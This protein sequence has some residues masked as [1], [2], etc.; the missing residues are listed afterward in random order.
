[1]KSRLIILIIIL[2]AVVILWVTSAFWIPAVVSFLP[3]ITD[4][5]ESINII[6]NLVQIFAPILSIF[7]SILIWFFRKEPIPEKPTPLQ[8]ATSAELLDQY[9]PSGGKINW[10]ERSAVELSD[11]SRYRK[12][13]I[14]GS[15]MI[16]KTRQAI[17]FIHQA[18]GRLVSSHRIYQLNS[19]DFSKYSASEILAVYRRGLNPQ[20]PLLIFID[21]LQY[22]YRGEAIRRLGEV[23]Q[24]LNQECHELYVL[25]TARTESL[26]DEH[27]Q[28]LENQVNLRVPLSTLDD[29]LMENLIFA[30]AGYHQIT[31]D[32]PL[33]RL[34]IERSRGVPQTVVFTL[35]RLADQRIFT[36]TLEQL[37]GNIILSLS[38]Q[39][40]PNLYRDIARAHP[41][42]EPLLESLATF[43]AVR[44]TP[45]TFLVYAYAVELWLRK[46]RWHFPGLQNL[47]LRRAL[48]HLVRYEFS[49]A[50]PKIN[51]NDNLVEGFFSSEIASQNLG[52]FLARYRYLFHNTFF[53]HLYPGA[54][55]HSDAL[56][57]LALDSYQR[58]DFQ[59]A[60]HLYSLAIEVHPHP[61]YYHNRGLSYA[62]LGKREEAIADYT[63]A[64][65]LFPDDADKASAFNNRG[66]SFYA[67][68]K[69][70]EA[71]DDF[72]Q[73][74]ALFTDEA[75][76]ASAFYNRG[77]SY[78]ALGKRQEAIADYTQSIALFT[79]DA[80]K[81]KAYGNRGASY[82][83]L[84]EYQKAI[85]DYTQAI[86]LFTDDADKAK[87]F[88]NRGV[89]YADLGKRQEAIADY[90]R[91]IAFYPDDTDKA[92]AFNNRGLS[93]ATLGKHQE[94]IADYT[95]AIA[96]FT[97]DA[98]KAKAF[99]NRGLTY[100][101][102]GK[103][104]EAI[105]DYTQAIA[106]F[107]D[108]VDKATAFYNRGLSY[109]ALGKRDEAIADYTQAIALYPA[110]ADK[111]K[112]F[113]NRGYT[114]ADLGKHQEAIDD[115]TQAIA[116][117]P[118]EADKASAF[119]NRGNSFY[120]LGKHQEAIA[121]YTQAIAFYPDDTDKATAFNNR[122]LSYAALGERREA[123]ADYTQSIALFTDD[124]D[125]AKAFFNRGR[126]YAALGEHPKAIA[127]CTQA[128]ALYPMEANKAKAYFGRANL[129]I[130][131]NRQDEAESDLKQAQ[132]LSPDNPYT[133]GGWAYLS[134][135]RGDYSASVEQFRRVASLSDGP[136]DWN[137][138]LAL[139]LLCLG[140]VDEA[141][142]LIRQRLA[143]DPHPPDL[144][145]MLQ[146]FDA[147]QQRQP[148]LPG[149]AEAITLLCSALPSSPDRENGQE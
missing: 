147:L 62:A 26:E 51:I 99:T 71:I 55:R 118:A 63:Q 46:Q 36:P 33:V 28:W 96:L 105:A 90:T 129:L 40:L 18:E 103:H 19:S 7:V 142:S 85:D 80:D 22:H 17:E 120:A 126:Y 23:L 70:Q 5:A 133:I 130:L 16:G 141:L 11:L 140:E 123:I 106:L 4:R 89:C 41:A 53:R 134:Y 144:L 108:D 20:I 81:A 27:R 148:D 43:Y 139:P 50:G 109:A 72:T 12:I 87:A 57:D 74:I 143:A 60:A 65:A 66:N 56:H 64:I 122:G 107:P 94:A 125:K 69:H 32:T 1:M 124:A 121:D 101:V 82:A 138:D 95:R 76:K 67:L 58:K 86:A 88:T 92:K 21:D 15:P 117:Y 97:D 68:G 25:I 73:A 13:A 91:A 146:W 45:Y 149:L 113:H 128:I 3:S 37:A 77:N 39:I 49:L 8:P 104:Q 42:A 52:H 135:A 14:L 145:D 93:C 10:I 116:L 110:E 79:D 61:G 115:Y 131:L 84:N 54:R 31:L 136:T 111:A 102:L 127:D 137:F 132:L 100:A 34:L 44:V 30:N 2:F 112:A 9:L 78:A 35:Q 24:N 114:Y 48:R 59:Q 119:N 6:S 47:A 98:D 75:D 29:R 38:T 83:A